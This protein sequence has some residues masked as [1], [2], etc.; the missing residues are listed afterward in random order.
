M[1]LPTIVGVAGGLVLT[2]WAPAQA[3]LAGS[4]TPGDYGVQ[5]GSQPGPG[6]YNVVFY[7]R[8]STDTIKDANGNTIRPLG[9]PPSTVATAIVDYL[10]FV[11]KS[12]IAGAHY[13]ALVALAW[14]NA[15]LEAPAFTLSE[16]TGTRFGDLMVRPFELGWHARRADITTGIDVYLP[17]G[18]YEPGG[19][20]NVGKGM[21]T[22]EPYVGTTIFLDEQRSTSVATVAFWQINGE[23][24]HTNAKVGQILTLEG[25]VGK[26]FMGGGVSVGMAY[27]VEWK[28]TKD[29]L[30][31]FVLPGGKPIDVELPDKHKVW[32]VG[33][34]V[35]LPVA[36]KSKLFALVNVRYLWET[37]ARVKTQGDTLVVTATLPIPS[38]KLK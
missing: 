12:T 19:D 36:S 26:T 5:A 6:F 27:Y 32:A 9:S 10:Y 17:T 22:Y 38:M 8:Y 31:E 21:V 30:G 3:Q 7:Y 14:V 4:H 13:G 37:G 11:S 25:G 34:D 2:L 28:I 24:K 18:R 1:R 29:Q 20:D 33:P 16:N 35:T 15:T 23:K